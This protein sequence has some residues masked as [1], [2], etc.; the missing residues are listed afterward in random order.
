MLLP[1]SLP[2]KSR[3]PRYR[4][5]YIQSAAREYTC[6]DMSYLS[7]CRKVERCGGE[8]VS[9]DS[10]QYAAKI[11]SSHHARVD[12]FAYDTH[13]QTNGSEYAA[14]ISTTFLVSRAFQLV[15]PFR[16]GFVHFRRQQEQ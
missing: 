3:K 2:D 13:V 14:A 15:K 8:G 7:V 11:V 5:S 1:N 9:I 16:D 6:F 4:T 10:P 12:V